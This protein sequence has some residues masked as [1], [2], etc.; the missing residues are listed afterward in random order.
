MEEPD[1]EWW[2]GIYEELVHT[3]HHADPPMLMP[4]GPEEPNV[5]E[6]VG[7]LEQEPDEAGEPAAG[8]V[9]DA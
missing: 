4:P 5:E 2:L 7:N 9:G 3:R 6:G 8:D 1:H